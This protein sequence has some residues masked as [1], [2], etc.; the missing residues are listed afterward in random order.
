MLRLMIIVLCSLGYFYPGTVDETGYL[1]LEAVAS[2]AGFVADDLSDADP[3]LLRAGRTLLFPSLSAPV[4]AMVPSRFAASIPGRY[5]IRA[6]PSSS[7]FPF[8]A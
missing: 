8:T 1:P 6:P 7:A 2:T 4:G 5:A 3:A